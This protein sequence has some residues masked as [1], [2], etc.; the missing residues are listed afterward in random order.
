MEKGRKRAGWPK[1]SQ[2]QK[3]SAM[4]PLSDESVE[5]IAGGRDDR[6]MP[7]RFAA[8]DSTASRDKGA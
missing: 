3:P 2:Q 5:A 4:R 1:K 6:H 7:P 8:N